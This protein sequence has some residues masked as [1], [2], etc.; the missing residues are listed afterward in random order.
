ME[1]R[2]GMDGLTASLLSRRSTAPIR[3]C[4]AETLLSA[5]GTA[6]LCS[7]LVPIFFATRINAP[8][9]KK[10]GSTSVIVT[11]LERLV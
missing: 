6:A 10:G 11:T 8:F 7:V 9:R 4:D 2:L 1:A 5:G 3:S